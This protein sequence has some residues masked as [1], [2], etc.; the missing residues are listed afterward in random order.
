MKQQFHFLAEYNRKTN[1][2]LLAIL[3]RED[4]QIPHR[5]TGAYYKSILGTLSHVLLADIVWIGRI[6]S[7]DEHLRAAAGV[8]PEV[9]PPMVVDN[10]WRDLSA[11]RLARQEVDNSFAKT[12]HAL[13]QERLGQIIHYKNLKGDAQAKPLWVILLHLF[14]HQTHHRGQVAALLDQAGV[15]N[16][17]SGLAPKFEP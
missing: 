7:D 3:E 1:L 4:P 8:L 12:V 10:T 9:G 2:D 15:A 5:Q 6:V 13:S 14:N 16:D 17:Y 11:F